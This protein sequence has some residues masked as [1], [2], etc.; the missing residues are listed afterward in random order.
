[1]YTKK[2][3]AA[4]KRA[5]TRVARENHVTEAQ[6]RKEILEAMEAGRSVPDP[7]VQARWADFH[8]AGAEPTVEEFVLWLSVQ[9]KRRRGGIL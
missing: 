8:Y 9:L 6:V 3:L 1:M 4:A 2:E 7:E 5:L